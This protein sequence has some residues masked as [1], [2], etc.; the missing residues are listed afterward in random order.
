[1]LRPSTKPWPARKKP[2]L[3]ST[4]R[5]KSRHRACGNPTKAQQAHQDKQRAHGCAMC[6]LL[7][8]DFK[9]LDEGMSPCGPTRIHHCNTG[10]L[11]GNLQLGQDATIGLGD[12]HHQGILMYDQSSFHLRFLSRDAM[13]EHFGPSLFHHKRA[14]LDLIAEKLGERSTAALQRWQ[15][16]QLP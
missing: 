4:K 8:L 6:R 13:R 3:P 12:W 5:M 11:A 2:L 16:A 15:E 10:D 9:D 1:M 14:F 7:G